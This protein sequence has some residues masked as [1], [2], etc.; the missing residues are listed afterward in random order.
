METTNA[1]KYRTM[2]DTLP[3]LETYKQFKRE[4]ARCLAASGMLI[5]KFRI[6]DDKNDA[7]M[8]LMTV[9]LIDAEGLDS[10]E[11]AYTKFTKE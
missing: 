2:W 5:C 8:A 3:K 6:T 1:G 7:L 9:L 10:D 4:E 11:N